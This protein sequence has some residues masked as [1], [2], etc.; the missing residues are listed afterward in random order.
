MKYH[1]RICTLK[2]ALEFLSWCRKIHYNY[3]K[4]PKWCRG[5]LGSGEHHKYCVERYTEIINLIKKNC[6]GQADRQKGR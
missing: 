6:R 5:Y 1:Q 3:T 2:Q 4:H